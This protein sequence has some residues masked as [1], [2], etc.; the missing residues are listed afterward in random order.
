MKNS[1]LIFSIIGFLMI[2][3][4]EKK[5]PVGINTHP[6]E[7]LKNHGKVILQ[8]SSFTLQ[9][10][11]TCHGANYQGG[12]SKVSCLNCHTYPHTDS[13]SQPSSGEFHGV[14]AKDAGNDKC[15]IC[16]GENYQ[17]GSSKI[18]CYTCHNYPH[19]SDWLNDD[20]P[21]FHGE[22][23]EE[24]GKEQC[25]SCHGTNYDGGTSGVSCLQCHSYPHLE[26]WTELGDPQFHGLIAKQ[27]QN[28]N[29][30]ACHGENFD[31]GTSNVSCFDCHT[32]P[33][34][35]T[36]S[37][38]ESPEFHGL[39]V[40]NIGKVS[41]QSCHGTDYTGGSSEVS[42]FNCHNYPH[43]DGFA[44]PGNENFHE[45]FLRTVINW[46]LSSCQACHGEDY[47]GGVAG[48]SC[49]TCHSSADGPEACNTCHGSSENIAPPL[50][51]SNNSE[52]GAVGVGA[53]QEHVS[54]DEVT[55]AY[56]CIVCHKAVNNF[57]DPDHIDETPHAEVIFDALATH[58][59]T[60]IAIWDRN[61]TT[62]SGVYCHGGF[63]FKKSESQ[64]QFAYTD[65][66]II[67]N[68][69]PVNWTDSDGEELCG[70]CHGLPPTGHFNIG[71]TINSCVL[72]HSSMVDGEGNI[73]DKSKHING[74]INLN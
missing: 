22:V 11:Q 54:A 48:Y 32:Y 58:G 8:D 12:A 18:S 2:S 65:S 43:Q 41:C 46:D 36:W 15:Q 61:T 55:S 6:S 63:V 16:H 26:G 20:S 44:L 60:L 7:W 5:E 40:L 45:N 19:L 9:S 4:S 52:S 56:N 68:T 1:I 69:D 17:G 49:I 31:G 59:G 29:C 13:W 25:Q 14:I 23:V 53:H 67:G 66:V 73:V 39:V 42:C 34:L 21:G 24:S 51:L 33:H 27:S 72:C 50:D 64:N 37:E 3:C 57:D 35:D 70:F 38:E 62:C 30:K 47:S 71:F 28:E 74:E 10:C